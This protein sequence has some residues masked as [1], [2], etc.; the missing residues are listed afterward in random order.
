MSTVRVVAGA[1]RCRFVTHMTFADRIFRLRSAV[2]HLV[3]VKC[4]ER[5]KTVT[6]DAFKFVVAYYAKFTRV[7]RL[8]DAYIAMA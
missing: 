4:G 3:R 1:A 6:E 8:C 2:L 7:R 5:F